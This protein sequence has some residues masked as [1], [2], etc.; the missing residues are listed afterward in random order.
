[1]S[2]SILLICY[3]YPPYPGTGGRRWAKI[4]KYLA[5]EG[6]NIHVINCKQ[7]NQ[8][9]SLWEEDVSHPNIKIHSISNT[10]EKA[11]KFF[12]SR[13]L[14]GIMNKVIFF[15]SK[16]KTNANYA[17]QSLWWCDKAYKKAQALIPDQSINVVIITCP[18]YHIM[19][20]FAAL[21]KEFPALK[22][23][24]DYRDIWT[25]HQTGKGFFAYLT[26]KRFSHEKQ[27]EHIAIDAADMVVTVADEMSRGISKIFGNKQVFTIPNG[28]D[29]ADTCNP[30]TIDERHYLKPDKINILFAGSLVQDSN[31]YAIPFFM[32]LAELAQKEPVL[33]SKINFCILGDVNPAIQKIIKDNQLDCVSFF[34]MLKPKEVFKLYLTFDYLLLFLIP[35][36]R[37]AF[38]SKF[39]DYLPARKP[40]ISVSEPGTFSE[41][42]HQNNLG[43]NIEPAMIYMELVKL[44]SKKDMLQIN[45]HFDISGFSYKESAKKILSIL[46]N[47]L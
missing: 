18:P 19:E 7:N 45:T 46:N 13:L 11:A 47:N 1:M 3:S 27:K 4:S 31:A 8:A 12:K 20:R 29:E 6:N 41:F 35:Y 44:L 15:L 37:Y 33:Y 42:L 39:F 16:V 23:V 26:D 40:I 30:V 22:L 38:I 10:S 28:F 36:Y 5:E 24:L 17:D 9:T 43:K 2:Y 21:K 14:S 34:P 32:A 25:I